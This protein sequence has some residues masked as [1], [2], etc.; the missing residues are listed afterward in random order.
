MHMPGW[1]EKNHGKYEYLKVAPVEIRIRYLP[2]IKQDSYR[3]SQQLDF[4]SAESVWC[5]AIGRLMDPQNDSGM[6]AE[7]QIGFTV[8]VITF[9][10]NSLKTGF[11]LSNV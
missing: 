10:F 5:T 1:T 6:M 7:R 8:R 3:F 9:Q 11:L 2:D 4:T